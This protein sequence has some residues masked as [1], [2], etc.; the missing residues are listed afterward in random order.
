MCMLMLSIGMYA[1]TVSSLEETTTEIS[2]DDYLQQLTSVDGVKTL[3]NNQ[4]KDVKTI[5][6]NEVRQTLSQQ[7][8]DNKQ[9]LINNYQQNSSTIINNT[10]EEL[11]NVKKS[12]MKDYYPALSNWYR[13][14]VKE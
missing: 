7:I 14:S 1:Q 3:V 4:I 11:K 8:A 10:K 5:I 9:A 13:T 6:S 12:M 2:S